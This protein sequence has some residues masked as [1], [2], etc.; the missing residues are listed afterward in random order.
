MP[1]QTFTF[2]VAVTVDTPENMS[3]DL[4]LG[5]L[6]ASPTATDYGDPETGSP[7]PA[8]ALAVVRNGDR[9]SAHLREAYIR[10]CIDDLGLHVSGPRTGERTYI[11]FLPPG[12]SRGRVA[13]LAPSGRAAIIVPP[14]AADD[15][16]TAVPLLNDGVPVRVKV[17]LTSE[18]AVEDAIALTKLAAVRKG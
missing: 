15:F 4:Q 6:G 1:A 7:L 16:E 2:T 11:N 9:F 13:S 12:V 14:E 3:V 18:Q 10:R 17:Y 8:E 5:D